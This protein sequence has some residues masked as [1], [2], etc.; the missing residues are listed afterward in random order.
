MLQALTRQVSP[1]FAE[2]ELT[3]LERQPI[4][5]AKAIAQHRA[6]E[7]CLSALGVQVISL[8]ADPSFP[9][10]VFVEDPAIVLDEVAVITRPGAA[11]RR[12]ETASIAEALSSYRELRF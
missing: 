11:S 3:F 4:D 5:L 8:P 7:A 9:D 1:N 2:C 12:G 10:A 6:Y